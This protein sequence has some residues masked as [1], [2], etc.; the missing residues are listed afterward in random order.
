M[1][2]PDGW[3]KGMKRVLEEREVD[4]ENMK[5]GDVRLILGGHDYIK[6]SFN[7]LWLRKDIDVTTSQNFT[8]SLN[9]YGEQQNSTQDPTVNTLFQD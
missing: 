3:P 8:V 6:L 9:G 2:L 5:T 4:T 7:I 1:L